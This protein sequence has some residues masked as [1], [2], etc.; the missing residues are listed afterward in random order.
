MTS[1]EEPIDT[2]DAVTKRHLEL[3]KRDGG[4]HEWVELGSA[5]TNVSALALVSPLAASV[6]SEWWQGHLRSLQESGGPQYRD[7]DLEPRRPRTWAPGKF[8]KDNEHAVLFN[9]EGNGA[10]RVF[11]RFAD[12]H[13][14]GHLQLVEVRIVLLDDDEDGN[15]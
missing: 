8:F 9:T 2:E 1:D 6:L 5:S 15:D 3:L 4:E 13:H 7:V 10:W 11:G 14:D 12:I